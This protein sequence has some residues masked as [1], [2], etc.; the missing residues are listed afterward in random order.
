MDREQTLWTADPGNV[1]SA[2]TACSASLISLHEKGLCARKAP[3]LSISLGHVGVDGIGQDSRI[4]PMMSSGD[5]SISRFML[6]NR[7]PI[8]GT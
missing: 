3:R 4:V 5:R 7:C 8:S 1:T 6:Q 2:G